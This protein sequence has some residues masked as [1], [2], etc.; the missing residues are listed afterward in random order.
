MGH[1]V[2]LSPLLCPIRRTSGLHGLATTFGRVPFQGKSTGSTMIKVQQQQQQQKGL[3]RR[4]LN[5]AGVH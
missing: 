1:N 4:T 5:L 2:F 3:M